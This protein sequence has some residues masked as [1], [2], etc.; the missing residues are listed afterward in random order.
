MQL[1]TDERDIGIK[2]QNWKYRK[3]TMLWSGS[4]QPDLFNENIKDPEKKER[5]TLLGWTDPDCISYRYNSYGFRDIEFDDRPAGIALGCSHTEGTGIPE[6][7]TW[8]KVLSK[9]LNIH[10]WNLGVGSSSYDTVFRLLD[11]WLPRLSPKF[12]VMLEPTGGRVE[13]FNN[14]NLPIN[15][16]PWSNSSHLAY[17]KLW[18]DSEIN[19]IISRRKNLLAMRQLCDNANT[20][21]KV[22][23]TSDMMSYPAKENLATARD[24]MHCGPKSHGIFAQKMYNLLPQ[25]IT[26]NYS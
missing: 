3:C 16:G 9:M 26:Q 6:S 22:L 14:H 23:K 4:D 19:D 15:V 12:V 2:H 20:I 5:L 7:T 25:E 17:Y 13:L 11:Y 24:L 18:V 21:F 8:C 10:V 1:N